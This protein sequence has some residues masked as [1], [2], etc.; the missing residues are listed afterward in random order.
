[1]YCNLFCQKGD[2]SETPRVKTREFTAVNDRVP[3]PAGN[4]AI[5]LLGNVLQLVFVRKGMRARRPG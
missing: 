1:M 2:E 4:E 5:S 3:N